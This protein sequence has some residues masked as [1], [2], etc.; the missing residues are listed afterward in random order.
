MEVA[1][2]QS[3]T[4]RLAAVDALDVLDNLQ[5]TLSELET[6]GAER[7][8]VLRTFRTSMMVDR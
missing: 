3:A 5:Q 4:C 1:E 8:C 7:Q 6:G 2:S